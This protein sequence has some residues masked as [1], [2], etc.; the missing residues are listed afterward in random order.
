MPGN[1]ANNVRSKDDYKREKEEQKKKLQAKRKGQTMK[2]LG[3]EF[4]L[5]ILGF[6]VTALLWVIMTYGSDIIF[7]LLASMS[8]H[9]TTIT[10]LDQMSSF[11]YF[12]LFLLF[13]LG[14]AWVWK[15]SNGNGAIQ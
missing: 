3:Y 5:F 13:V 1:Y 10:R 8:T 12:S 6:I 9:A 7:P 2:G 4:F 14:I 11:M 15:T